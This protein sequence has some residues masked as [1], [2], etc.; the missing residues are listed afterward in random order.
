VRRLNLASEPFRN[1][2]LPA[3][4]TVLGWIVV[5]GLTI[6]HAVII[7]RL[8]PGRTSAAHQELEKLE[9]EAAQ[10]REESQQLRVTRPEGAVV[11][12]W[13]LLKD[14]VD[15]R[16]FSWTGLFSV[17]EAALP[18]DVRLLTVTP[19]LDKGLVTLEFTAVARSYEQGLELIQ[20]LEDRPEFSDVVPK[21]RD[22]ADQ[23]RFQYQMRYQPQVAASPAPGAS[24]PPEEATEADEA[25]EEDEDQQARTASAPGAR[26]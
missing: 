2:T 4:L 20:V 1:E 19:T 12:Q 11:T 21:T 23:S 14:L 16:A 9:Q 17:F 24:P 8:L 18:P 6:Q 7:R 15:Q 26:P 3:V 10:L 5:A 13:T 25:E 22:T